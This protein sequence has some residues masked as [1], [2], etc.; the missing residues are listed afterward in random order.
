[1][2]ATQ[3]IK[4]RVRELEEKMKALEA[5][6]EAGASEVMSLLLLLTSSRSL[7]RVDPDA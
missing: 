2:E 1:M 6:F 4:A 3:E 7:P 5:K